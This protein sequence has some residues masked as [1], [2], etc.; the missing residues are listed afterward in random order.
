LIIE[1][2]DTGVVMHRITKMIVDNKSV[3]KAGKQDTIYI[4]LNKP[5]KRGDRVYL[6]RKID[7]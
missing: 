7:K 2:R 5:V 6:F 3:E 1:G 4:K